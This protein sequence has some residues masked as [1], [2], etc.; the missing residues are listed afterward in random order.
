M[1]LSKNFSK[2]FV[3]MNGSTKMILV[4]MRCKVLNNLILHQ[5]NGAHM[6]LQYYKIFGHFGC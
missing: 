4:R 1:C 3:H 6:S 5:P 2:M